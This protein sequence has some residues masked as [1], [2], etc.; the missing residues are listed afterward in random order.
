MQGF[1]GE[2]LEK[3]M[4]ETVSQVP[5]GAHNPR[6]IYLTRRWSGKLFEAGVDNGE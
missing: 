2:P 1:L 3:K 5:S 6:R 4:P